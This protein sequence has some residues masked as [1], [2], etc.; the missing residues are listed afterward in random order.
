VGCGWRHGGPNSYGPHDEALR[1]AAYD[2]RM[3]IE[4]PDNLADLQRNATAALE[5]V[6]EHRRQIGLPVLEWTEEQTA[7]SVALMQ[8]AIAAAQSLRDAIN[9]SGLETDSYKFHRALKEAARDGA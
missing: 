4:I 2:H 5:A 9:A 6:G 1:H 3:S 8:A 7:A